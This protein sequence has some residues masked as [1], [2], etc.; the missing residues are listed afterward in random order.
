MDEQEL[1]ELEVPEDEV[2]DWLERSEADR[3]AEFYAALTEVA[4]DAGYPVD[5]RPWPEAEAIDTN[6][7]TSRDEHRIWVSRAIDDKRAA[8]TLRPVR[9]NTRGGPVTSRSMPSHR[10]MRCAGTEGRSSWSE[11]P[12]LRSGCP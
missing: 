8:T 5:R 1:D 2:D 6:G 9:S 3:L 10:M 11:T 12:K 4:S 7:Y